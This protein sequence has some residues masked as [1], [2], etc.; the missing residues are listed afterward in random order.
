MGYCQPGSSVHGYS[1]GNTTGVGCH[2]LPSWRSSQ[3]RDQTHI[4]HIESRFFTILGTREAQE[5][6]SGWPIP[7]LVDLPDP[8][9]EPGFP[10]LQED[11]L[12][13]ELL[14]KSPGIFY[15]FIQKASTP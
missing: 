10:A 9:I 1:P 15:I 13:A 12:P 5:Y 4:S 7:S 11:S 8:G 3:P 2:A 14:G 6:W